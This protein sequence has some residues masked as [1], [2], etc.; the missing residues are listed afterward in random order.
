MYSNLYIPTQVVKRNEG[1]VESVAVPSKVNAKIMIVQIS[2]GFIKNKM[3]CER[4]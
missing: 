3:N 4:I 2:E 1:L